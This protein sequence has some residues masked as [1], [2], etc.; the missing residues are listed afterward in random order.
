MRVTP[1]VWIGFAVFVGYLAL[2]TVVQLSSGIPFPEWG[3]NARNLFFGSG[4]SLIIAS[5]VLAAVITGLGWWRPVL[6]E[7]EPSRHR[8]ALIAPAL[9]ALIAIAG[10][11]GSEWSAVSGAFL[12]AALVLL[13][14]GFT[15]EVTVRGVLLVA[16]RS[17]MPEVWV[18][19]ITTAAF[20]LMHLVNIVLGQSVA[21]TLSQVF[22]AFMF[23]NVL[24]VLRRV[25]GTLLPAM[26]LHALWDFSLFIQGTGAVAPFA[27]V[28][29]VLLFPAWA[30]SLVA[31]FFVV[32]GA[33]ERVASGL[34]P[35]R[36]L[37]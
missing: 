26:A 6:R 9:M 29:G 13:L 24:Y 22:S 27:G 19:L 23:G 30:L 7:R 31:V 37:A 36:S 21:S 5:I 34:R 3:D 20:A 14:V 2:I 18:W 28:V 16:L 1:R 17:R 11:I 10:L 8:W 35:T 12:A 33:D 4:L 25:A 32:R 15:E